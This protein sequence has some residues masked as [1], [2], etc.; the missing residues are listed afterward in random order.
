MDARKADPVRYF[1]FDLPYADGFDLRG[2]ALRL[3]RDALRAMID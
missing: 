2:V 1:A 3:R